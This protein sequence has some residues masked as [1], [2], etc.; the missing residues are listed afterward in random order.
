MNI[1]IEHFEAAFARVIEGIETQDNRAHLKKRWTRATVK[2][3]RP[4]N[5]TTIFCLAAGAFVNRLNSERKNKRDRLPV[6]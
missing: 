6:L 3:E 2:S 1:D 4:F 5:R